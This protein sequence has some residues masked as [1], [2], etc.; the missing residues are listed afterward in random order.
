MNVERRPFAI[1][2]ESDRRF[3]EGPS[4]ARRSRIGPLIF[5]FAT[6]AF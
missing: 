1:G 6:V 2:F 5:V 4:R 3:S